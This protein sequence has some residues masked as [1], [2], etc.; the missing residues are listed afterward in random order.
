MSDFSIST[1]V[2]GQFCYVI[3][4][5]AAFIIICVSFTIFIYDVST[6]VGQILLLM[7]QIRLWM[8]YI[9]IRNLL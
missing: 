4:T 6:L 2:I 8:I 3:I 1:L 5:H 7:M 9:I